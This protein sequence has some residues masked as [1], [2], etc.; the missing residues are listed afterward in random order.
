[1]E[2]FCAAIDS[3][4]HELSL[5]FSENIMDLL[6]TGATLIRKNGFRSFKTAVVGEMV[7]KYYPAD[8]SEQ[9]IYAL[10]QQLCHFVV[11][12]IS[13]QGIETLQYLGRALPMPC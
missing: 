1:M 12:D 3:E 5:R 9:D 11:D 13:C 4:L 7:K 8:F 10:E 6:S 2:I